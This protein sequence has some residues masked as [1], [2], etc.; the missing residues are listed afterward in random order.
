MAHPDTWLVPH[1]LGLELYPDPPL[2]KACLTACLAG[3]YVSQLLQLKV[4]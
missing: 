4:V 1:V 3:S 2:A